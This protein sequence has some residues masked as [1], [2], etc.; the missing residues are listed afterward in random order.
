MNEDHILIMVTVL[1]VKMVT[2]TVV[3]INHNGGIMM[4]IGSNLD[5]DDGDG[6]DGRD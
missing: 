4:D 3:M 2:I 5:S 6:N 1:V